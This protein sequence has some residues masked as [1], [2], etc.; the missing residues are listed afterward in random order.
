MRYEIVGETAVFLLDNPKSERSLRCNVSFAGVAMGRD[1]KERLLDAVCRYGRGQSLASQENCIAGFL[2]G[3]VSMFRELELEYPTTSPDWQKLLLDFLRFH[4]L[5]QIHSKLSVPNRIQRWKGAVRPTLAFLLEERIIPP[6]VEIPKVDSRRE[7]LAG[8]APPLLGRRPIG[9]L[10]SQAS[11]QKLLVNIEFALNDADYLARI[12]HECRQKI[13]TLKSVCVKHWSAMRADHESGAALARSIPEE[14]IE[15]CIQSGEYR[16]LAPGALIDSPLASAAL[17]DGHVW[18]LAVGKRLLREGPGLDCISVGTLR[19]TP[20]FKSDAFNS[21]P[22]YD[23]LS[24]LSALPSGAVERL[25][26]TKQF[27]R[28]L[29]ILSGVDVAAACC[30]LMIEHP[31]FTPSSLQHAQLCNE[32][33]RLYLEAGMRFSLDKPR[34]GAR[35]YVVLSELAQEI[36]TYVITATEPIRRLMRNAG[37]KAWRYLFLGLQEGG[38]VGPLH[39]NPTFSLTRDRGSM[40]RLYP[41]LTEQGLGAGTLDFRR[42]RNTMGV[43]RWF[44]TGS[45]VEMSR[46][47]GNSRQVAL[48]HYLPPALLHAWNARLIRRFQNT[49]IILAAHEEDYLVEVS[50]F[51]SLGEL[52]GFIAQLLEEHPDRTSPIASQL[53]IRLGQRDGAGTDG[54]LLNVRCSPKALAYLYAFDAYAARLEESQ[55]EYVDPLTGLSARHLI[56]LSR[57]I[58]HA[59]E[60]PHVEISLREVLDLEALRRCHREALALESPLRTRFERFA[61]NNAWVLT[62]CAA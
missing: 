20:F 13:A 19:R 60:N 29:G 35:K 36:V 40:I 11:R 22:Y 5:D 21:A 10:R 7:P 52:L 4:L 54:R 37:H 8:A 6:G 32:R 3:F 47:L 59:C 9:T 50:D 57:M 61:F 46:C 38:N 23:A 18:G 44:E 31:Q 39:K 16:R 51:A 34:A 1:S 33:G 58:R 56:D 43:L 62:A 24:R 27:Y 12:E 55:R 15:A 25:S 2:K 42:V 26:S 53:H 49:L 28:F 14:K 45:L 30:L 41:E 17:P 48:T